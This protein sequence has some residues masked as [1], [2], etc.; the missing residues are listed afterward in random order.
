MADPYLSI[1]LDTCPSQGHDDNRVSQVAWTSF[2]IVTSSNF[3]RY[4]QEFLVYL[5][6]FVPPVC[7]K[8]FPTTLSWPKHL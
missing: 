2:Y 3:S 7:T 1:F 4:P 5:G 6:K 8:V